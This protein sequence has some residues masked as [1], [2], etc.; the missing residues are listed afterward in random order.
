MDIV[1]LFFSQFYWVLSGQCKLH[2]HTLTLFRTHKLIIK[3]DKAK[4]NNNSIEAKKKPA[5]EK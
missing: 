1:F 3:M 2:T 5:N 4:Q